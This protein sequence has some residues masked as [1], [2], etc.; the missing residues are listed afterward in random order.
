MASV[1]VPSPASTE[2]QHS[3]KSK[4]RSLDHSNASDSMT[5]GNIPYPESLEDQKKHKHPKKM[6]QPT[7]VKGKAPSQ[8][9]SPPRIADGLSDNIEV[10]L[11]SSSKGK[12]LSPPHSQ[13][14]V[15]VSEFSDPL[16]LKPKQAAKPPTPTAPPVSAPV[17]S[18]V[19]EYQRHQAKKQAIQAASSQ[20]GYYVATDSLYFNYLI[21]CLPVNLMDPKKEDKE[22]SDTVIV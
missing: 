15:P 22:G 12:G 10:P 11:P 4:K 19:E 14:Y 17:N 3:L 6:A 21:P 1:Y 18:M 13:N 5:S 20:Y 2:Q 16:Q 9:V 8:R 7:Q